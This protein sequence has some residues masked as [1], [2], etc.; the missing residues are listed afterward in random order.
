MAT[1]RLQIR[2]KAT[3]RAD[4][5][6]LEI[7]G[8]DGTVAELTQSTETESGIVELATD[9]EVQA[10]LDT[11]R[12][13]TAANLRATLNAYDDELNIKEGG[14]LGIEDGGSISLGGGVFT[15]FELDS[16]SATGGSCKGHLTVNIDGV[17]A[18]IRLYTSGG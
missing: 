17:D 11:E 13:I 1:K 8:G 2:D 4:L 10:G 15:G 14:L 3:G 12:A 5:Y 7:I 16:G 9:A 6:E 18:L